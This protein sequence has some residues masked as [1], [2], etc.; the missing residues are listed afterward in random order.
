[1]HGEERERVRAREGGGREKNARNGNHD[2]WLAYR[3][4]TS[5]ASNCFSRDELMVIVERTSKQE[6]KNRCSGIEPNCQ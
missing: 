5:S 3:H 1:M 4:L 6:R 2:S